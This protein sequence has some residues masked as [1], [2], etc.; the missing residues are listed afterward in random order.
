M[1][2]LSTYDTPEDARAETERVIGEYETLDEAK[3]AAPPEIAAWVLL[4]EGEEVLMGIGDPPSLPQGGWTVAPHFIV[5]DSAEPLVPID[6]AVPVPPGEA[7]D[8]GAATGTYSE[9]QLAAAALAAI[10]NPILRAVLAAGAQALLVPTSFEWV[11]HPTAVPEAW[12]LVFGS[13]TGAHVFFFQREGMKA[14]AEKMLEEIG[15]P[16]VPR[17]IVAD[18]SA[19]QRLPGSGGGLLPPH[20]G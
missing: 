9:E 4:P 7:A 15:E 13:P 12:A 17:L 16:N 3:G 2:K 19:L 18:A 14:M 5:S 8:N 10:R 6:E 1:F 11:K 20:P